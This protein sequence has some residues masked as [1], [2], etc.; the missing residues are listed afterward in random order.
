MVRLEDWEIDYRY[1]CQ[2]C[3]KLRIDCECE[4]DG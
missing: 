1:N 2:E 3:S 4:V